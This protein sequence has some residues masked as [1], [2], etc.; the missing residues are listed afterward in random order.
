WQGIKFL[1]EGFSARVGLWEY[2]DPDPNADV[3]GGF[4]Q[5]AVK[6]LKTTLRNPSFYDLHREAD[7]LTKLR[8]SGSPHI[9]HLLH[10][11]GPVGANETLPLGRWD[12]V[13]RRIFLEYCSLGSLY[14]LLDRRIKLQASHSL[15]ELTIWRLF[16]CLLDGISVLDY[17]NELVPDGVTNEFY[18]PQLRSKEEI[19][20]FDL[21]PAN[22]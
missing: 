21:K 22:S 18:T 5:I 3:P 7:T 9:V 15:I 4:R 14:D 12:N 11:P 20:H 17:G 6:E 16:D 19:V 1:G 2:S 8:Q 13:V 10:N